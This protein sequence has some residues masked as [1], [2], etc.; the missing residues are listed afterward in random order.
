MQNKLEKWFAIFWWL[1]FLSYRSNFARYCYVVYFRW[2]PAW[3]WCFFFFKLTWKFLWI[4]MFLMVVLWKLL[5]FFSKN[6]ILKW[7]TISYSCIM[8]SVHFRVSPIILLYSLFF[9]N[10]FAII[11]Y[12]KKKSKN[13]GQKK[14]DFCI[15]FLINKSKQFLGP[16]L[17]G[18][19]SQLTLF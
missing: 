18:I 10:I 9:R 6:I 1:L 17:S 12:K 16:L 14:N 13:S 2:I 7:K 3:C 19:N 15:Y 11:L 4:D 8:N 5:P